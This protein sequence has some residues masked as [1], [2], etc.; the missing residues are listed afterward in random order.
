M[1]LRNIIT[2]SIILPLA[3]KA[4]GQNIYMQL[5]FLK[6]SQWWSKE[7]L[8]AYQNKKLQDLIEHAYKNVPYYTEVMKERGL[9]PKDITTVEDL[10]KLPILTKEI[11]KENYPQKLISKDIS[12][13]KILNRSSSG[14]TGTPIQYKMTREGYSFNKACNLR[15]WDWMGFRL[16]DKLIKVSQNKRSTFEKRLQDKINNTALF[17][18]EY[19]PESLADFEK[20]FNKFKPEFL[21][22]YPDPLQFLA[23]QISE[24]EWDGLKAV[25]TTGNIL[26]PEI[27]NM[28]ENKFK[29]KIFDS[30]SCEGGPNFFEC[31]THECYHSSMEYGISEILDDNMNEVAPG[32]MGRLFTTD[33]FNYASPFI[34]YDSADLVEKSAVACS[35]GRELLSITK[36][37]GRD[38]DVIITPLKQYLIAQTFTTYFKYIP[39][40]KQFQVQQPSATELNFSLLLS[41]NHPPNI[42][43]EVKDYW[44]AYIKGYMVVNVQRVEKIPLTPS[45][46]RRFVIRNKEITF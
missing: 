26:F 33:L 32:E 46:K 41:K 1:S 36:V 42:L 4:T 35:C 15:G 7:Q 40:V 18:S 27:R 31:P 25:N 29:V 3:D 14:S 24:F 19:T 16:G 6:E 39:S 30:Y 37:I 20:L 45:G 13:Y 22:S 9:Q 5:R 8:I 11:F 21:R 10:K 23:L 12:K 34:R 2:E 43:E 38:N 28:I 17:S 44:F